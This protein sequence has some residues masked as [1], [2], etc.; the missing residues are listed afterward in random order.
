MNRRFFL[1]TLAAVAA[2]V[3]SGGML[4]RAKAEAGIENLEGS[5]LTLRDRSYG[6]GD[7]TRIN[8]LIASAK[9]VDISNCTFRGVR[10]VFPCSVQGAIIQDC[11]FWSDTP[12]IDVV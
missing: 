7:Q 12:I 5:R 2:A 1:R 6:P 10:L 3:G 9:T 4:S 11:S 8:R